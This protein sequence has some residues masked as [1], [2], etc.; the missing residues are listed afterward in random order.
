MSVRTVAL[1]GLLVS[2]TEAS[3]ENVCID[4]DAV[5]DSLKTE[6][7][8][9]AL[10]VFENTLLVQGTQLGDPCEA[11]TL[12]HTW[13][14]DAIHV[15]LTTPRG[16]YT[17]TAD[18][19]GDL[20][21]A[22]EDLVEQAGR[23][24]RQVK[25]ER[26]ARVEYEPPG[27]TAPTPADRK[28]GSFY[29]RVGYGA[30]PPMESW[31]ALRLGPTLGLGYRRTLDNWLLDVSILNTHVWEDSNGQ[32]DANVLSFIRLAAS[33]MLVD[34]PQ[35]AFYV[36][37]ALSFG[38][39]AFSVENADYFSETERAYALQAEAVA[40]YEFMRDK[41]LRVFFEAW[42]VVPIDQMKGIAYA[43]DPMSGQQ[44]EDRYE[45]LAPWTIAVAGGISF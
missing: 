44:Y 35:R 40:G 33:R 9:A 21:H 27:V 42:L 12:S 24:P 29:L 1:L 11:W 16:S 13:L 37:G 30:S 43:Y 38:Q 7:Q 39:P 45:T 34:E 19:L 8:G 22:Y 32:Y 17:S 15:L 36:G 5:R 28:V 6:E 41:P 31:Q 23:A 10:R 14:G 26:L 25:P 4:I 3:A 18:G 20:G 2:A